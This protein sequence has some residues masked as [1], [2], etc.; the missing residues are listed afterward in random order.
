[1]TKPNSGYDYTR[2]RELLA[3]ACDETKRLALI[4]LLI[5]ERA[6]DRLAAQHASDRE[7]LTASTIAALLDSRSQNEAEVVCCV[8]VAH[9][10]ELD[11]L[12]R[13]MSGQHN[14]PLRVVAFNTTER[15]SEDLSQDVAREIMRRLGLAGDDVPSS[16][17]SFIDRHLGSDRQ[18]TLRLA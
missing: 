4:D 7:A 8:G 9:A 12:D 3:E 1:M 16:L 5:E 15:W 13:L 17:E 11:P 6:R 18:L 14:D 10:S 2:Y